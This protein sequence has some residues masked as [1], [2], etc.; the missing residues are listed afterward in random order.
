YGVV[1]T[2]SPQ[3]FGEMYVNFGLPG[4]FFGSVIQGM[5]LQALQVLWAR[6][7]EY[8]AEHF[9]IYALGSMTFGRWAIGGLLGPIQYG[10]VT[11]PVLY[12]MIRMGQWLLVGARRSV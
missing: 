9:A 12:A 11:L 8:R 2:A 1:G 10:M 6:R 5:F 4:V 7:R 3:C